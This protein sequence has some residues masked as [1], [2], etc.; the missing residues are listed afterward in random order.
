[1]ARTPKFAPICDG[2]ED[3]LEKLC[4]WHY[5][6]EASNIYFISLGKYLG[7]GSLSQ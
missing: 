7:T 6:I 4:K 3:S 5:L 2:I 1:M